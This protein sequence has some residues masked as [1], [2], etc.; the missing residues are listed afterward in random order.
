MAWQ[1]TGDGIEWRG[2]RTVEQKGRV[3][4]GVVRKSERVMRLLSL[5]LDAADP[6]PRATDR[7]REAR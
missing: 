2:E 1:N 7:R 6:R 5:T 3:G 4:G